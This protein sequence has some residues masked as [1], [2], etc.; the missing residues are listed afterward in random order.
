[1][2]K[3]YITKVL[4]NIFD[5]LYSILTKQIKK[6]KSLQISDEETRFDDWYIDEHM[7]N[8][9]DEKQ[10]LRWEGEQVSLHELNKGK[11]NDRDN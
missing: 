7:K 9:I 5:W 3:I 6:Q 4:R 1:M 2:T 11:K 10:I 8:Y